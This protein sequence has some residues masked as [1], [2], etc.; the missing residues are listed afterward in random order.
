MA[1]A[2]GYIVSYDH[3]G[4]GI[5]IGDGI[6]D[7]TETATIE[8]LQQMP[9]GQGSV[10]YP[11]TV[12]LVTG[13][14][15]QG[16]SGIYFVPD[17][18]AGFPTWEAGTITGYT[19]ATEGNTGDDSITGTTGRD[20]I[21]DTDQDIYNATGTDVIDGGDGDDVI[22]FGD[23][24]D[25][26][27]GGDGDDLIG[28]WSTG[29]GSN[30][31]DGG[32]G[33]DI[34]VGGSGDDVIT[35][36][37]GDDWLSG[38]QGADTLDGGGGM[39]EIWVTDD[40]DSATV[41]GGEA[42]SDWDLLGFSNYTSTG[43]VTVTYTGNEAGN[44]EF[45]AT[46]TSGSFVEIEQITG[47]ECDDTIDASATTV[48]T[49][50]YT[51]W[52]N[53]IVIGGSG[54]D[55]FWGGGSDDT[56]SGGAGDDQIWGDEGSDTLTGGTGSD[57][58]YGGEGND[59]F[60]VYHDHEVTD[61]HGE[62][63][64][65]TL[66]LQ[67]DGSAASA[68]ITYSGDTFGSYTLGSASGD[69]SSIEALQTTD[70]ADIFDASASN[71]GILATTLGGEDSVTGGGGDDQI[72]LGDGNDAATG[73][74]GADLIYGQAG[75]D[76]LEGGAGDDTLGGGTGEDRIVGGDGDDTLTG[77]DG[78]DTFAVLDGDGHATITDF[79]LTGPSA[80]RLDLSELTDESGN[81]VD[82]DDVVVS[83]DGYGNAVLTF[84]MGESLTLTG[85]SA[86]ELDRPTLN[87]IGVPC[88]TAGARVMTSKGEIAVEQ[89]LPGD[90][91]QTLDDGPQPVLWIG[92]RR[93]DQADLL[94]NPNFY[95]VLIREGALGNRRDLL[96]S[97]QHGL[98][99][100][101][102]G[103][104][105]SFA[106]AIHLARNGGP[107]FRV[108]RGVRKVTYVHLLF[109]RHQVIL[110]EGMA[111]ES[112]Y[113][114][115]MAM[116]GLTSGDRASIA[117]LFPALTPGNRSIEDVGKLYSPTA[118]HFLRRNQIRRRVAADFSRRRALC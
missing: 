17:D 46:S 15:Y 23:G 99:T 105:P 11:G 39:D 53:D 109:E 98:L 78:A 68:T 113:P 41:I 75:D 117:S 21:V 25:V 16:E 61:I 110:T 56:L 66:V 31:I 86:S 72:W 115:P 69:F 54:D 60:Y 18:A 14:F 111:S 5:G 43:G 63:W 103:D 93:I 91:V 84:P 10:D 22:V 47:T 32:A 13:L 116:K 83:D 37:E 79:T 80:D 107:G 81:P 64:W 49:S 2:T 74:D 101:P 118:R 89:L 95:P 42:G 57:V 4:D 102:G 85:I 62:G 19:P 38:A 12:G 82:L 33:N 7:G 67:D 94:A 58:L 73:G 88:F 90:L 65:D 48:G 35:G 52:G 9:V 1:T 97:P 29:S 114:G 87:A 104:E 3:N 44:F 76:V 45:D 77:G 24:D 27:S 20:V 36:G 28:Q 100:T 59:T 26:I 6:S 96:V 106:R 8:D 108:A 92:Q 51:A 112:F 55:R 40:H 30:T 70:N 34:I 71:W 50:I